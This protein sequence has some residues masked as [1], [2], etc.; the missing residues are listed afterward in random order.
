MAAGILSYDE[1]ELATGRY[2]SQCWQVDQAA[3]CMDAHTP[4]C[5]SQLYSPLPAG[6]YELLKYTKRKKQNI[7]DNINNRYGKMQYFC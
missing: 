2:V 3:Y 1:G 6:H 7:L 4:P 5:N